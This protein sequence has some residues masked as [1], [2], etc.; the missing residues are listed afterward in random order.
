MGNRLAPQRQQ[1]R[2]NWG[3]WEIGW[4]LNPSTSTRIWEIGWHLN[5]GRPGSVDVFVV[6]ADD[7]VGITTS[8]Q[9]AERL[10]LRTADG[11]LVQGPFRIFEFDT[12]VG[13]ASPLNRSTPG[14]VPG[15]LT[16]GGA[17][18]FVVPNLFVDELSNLSV[19]GVQ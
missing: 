1:N 11:S 19:W 15:G 14:F 17:R 16:A 6:A 13:I 8:T 12:P 5:P 7:L 4:H 18:E 9:L 2:E 3:I 10:A